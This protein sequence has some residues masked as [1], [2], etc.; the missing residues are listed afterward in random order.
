M[1]LFRTIAHTASGNPVVADEMASAY[2]TV[3]RA[4]NKNVQVQR[5]MS[6]DFSLSREFAVALTAAEDALVDLTNR[7]RTVGAKQAHLLARKSLDEEKLNVAE[8][9]IPQE[10][11]EVE[12]PIL[13][14]TIEN[15]YP[16]VERLI[17]AVADKIVDEHT[18]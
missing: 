2:E 4:V 7:F 12:A 1:S 3:H 10:V 15:I 11:E 14:D 9:S 5:T 18:R 6:A 16:A 13:P 8:R 17:A